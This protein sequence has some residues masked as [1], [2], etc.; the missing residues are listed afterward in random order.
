MSNHDALVANAADEQQVKRAARKEADVK[1]QNK[2]D[3]RHVLGTEPGRRLIWRILGQCR[4]FESVFAANPAEAGY[5]SGQQDVGH[6]I[7]AWVGDADEQALV[8]LMQEAYNSRRRLRAENEASRI[9]SAT[10][11]E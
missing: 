5:R 2:A 1:R 9:D 3:L 10:E 4:T 8:R 6:A 11:K 7:M